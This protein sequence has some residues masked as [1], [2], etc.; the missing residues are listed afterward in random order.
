MKKIIKLF[1]E[2]GKETVIVVAIGA[3]AA[4]YF[5]HEGINPV[6][7]IGVCALVVTGFT[8]DYLR[9]AAK[10]NTP[11]RPTKE[12]LEMREEIDRLESNSARL[13]KELGIGQP[14]PR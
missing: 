12:M 9:K 7:A 2:A 1:R 13:R 11:Y 14:K 5:I 3:A 4:G 6:V 10:A 8:I